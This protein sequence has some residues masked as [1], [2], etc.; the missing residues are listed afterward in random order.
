MM[1]TIQC[2]A[3]LFDLDGVLIDSRA[4]V[5]DAWRAWA[6]TRGFDPLAVIS[7]SHGQRTIDTVRSLAPHLDAGQEASFVADCRRASPAPSVALKGAAEMLRALP[8]DRWAVVTSDDR[9]F[10]QTDMRQCGL[11]AARVLVA[12][13]DIPVGKPHPYGY[14]EA[15]RMLGVSP[16]ACVVFEDAPAGIEAGLRAGARVIA[17]RTTYGCDV[18]AAADMCLRSLTN[19]HVICV[20]DRIELRL[21]V[22]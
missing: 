19:V 8:P 17:L 14:L 4:R 16:A 6:T 22:A 9:S 10:A 13:N 11:P 2:E 7:S 15:A 18:L 1:T 12:G 5:E 21:Q 3:V 20:T